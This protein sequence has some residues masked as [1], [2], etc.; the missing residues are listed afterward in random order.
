MPLVSS[1]GRLPA[2]IASPRSFAKG[3][4]QRPASPPISRTCLRVP[5]GISAGPVA[6]PPCAG[7]KAL[8]AREPDAIPKASAEAR[9]PRKRGASPVPTAYPWRY[10][11]RSPRRRRRCR[12]TPLGATREA[13][14]LCANSRWERCLRLAWPEACRGWAA[15][16]RAVSCAALV[17]TDRAGGVEGVVGRWQTVHAVGAPGWLLVSKGAFLGPVLVGAER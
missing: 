17:V 6:H 8:A 5:R 13:W 4:C 1:S 10:R 15:H 3:S 9:N 7:S 2:S 11:S 16:C 14:L 12:S